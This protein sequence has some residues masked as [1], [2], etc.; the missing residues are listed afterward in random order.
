MR[1]ALIS[2]DGYFHSNEADGL[3]YSKEPNF[4]NSLPAFLLATKPALIRVIVHKFI[5]MNLDLI[6]QSAMA[7]NVSVVFPD[8][9]AA[10]LGKLEIAY[11]E[12]D[13]QTIEQMLPD[14]LGVLC[15]TTGV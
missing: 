14:W 1:Y 3:R 4:Y 6:A 10:Y 2:K 11:E 12:D 7:D 5:E 13:L 8:A 15:D 9:L